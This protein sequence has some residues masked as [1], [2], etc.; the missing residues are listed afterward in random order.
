[1]KR[2]KIS[3]M[4]L[5]DEKG[6][7]VL[8]NGLCFICRDKDK[9]YLEPNI[10][11]KLA[12]YAKRGFNVIRLGIFWDGVE[13]EPGKYD[14]DYLN[15]VAEVVRFAEQVGL[16]VFLDMHQDLF[17]AKF[18]DGAPEWATLDDGLD[19]PEEL[20][21]WYEAYLS[22]PAV[23]RAADH[24]WGNH[25]AVDGVGL[26]DHYEA[27]WEHIASRFHGYSNIIGFEP[28]NEPY[29]GSLAPKAFGEAFG[30]IMQNN[31]SFDPNSPQSATPSERELMMGIL[32]EHFV[33]FDK[34]ILMPFYNRMLRAIRKVGNIPIVTGSNIYGTAVKTGIEK[35]RDSNGVV[36]TQQIFAPHGYD[37][38]VDT[39]RYDEYNKEHVTEIF[40]QKRLSQLE[41]QLPVIVGEWG[42]FPS[43]AFTKSLIEHMTEILEQYHWSSTYH[44]YVAGM[45]GDENYSSLERGYPVYIAGRLIAYRYDYEQKRLTVTWN[46]VK[47][48][49]SKLYLPDL[50]SM[51]NWSVSHEAEIELEPIEGEIGGYVSV[52]AREEGVL[53][54]VIG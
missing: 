34:E 16:Y 17:S 28:M 46:A 33:T 47:D 4:N 54:A 50:R 53:E 38:V 41:L 45:E 12:F 21:I 30:A 20:T 42:N 44:Q 37:T 14:D 15:R 26:L 10:E 24:F 49:K 51:N 35:V 3:G 9:G 18:I 31:P 13:P 27:M 19:H 22:S 1:M 2:L 40:A 7:Q 43:G 6:N 48:G 39:D 36:D 8:L 11:S 32:T 52:S 29:I 25:P 23:I 5:V